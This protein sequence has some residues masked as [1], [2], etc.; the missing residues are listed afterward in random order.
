MCIY[1]IKYIFYVGDSLWINNFLNI[2]RSQCKHICVVCVF[3]ADGTNALLASGRSADMLEH[4]LISWLHLGVSLIYMIQYNV[5]GGLRSF[6]YSYLKLYQ[7]S[8]SIMIQWSVVL[9]KMFQSCLII[10]ENMPLLIFKQW[11]K[12]IVIAIFR[13]FLYYIHQ[14]SETKGQLNW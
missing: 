4:R 11:V 3:A 13:H 9:N 6:C 2:N 5:L 12:A 8:C 7:W 1:V 14:N 10:S